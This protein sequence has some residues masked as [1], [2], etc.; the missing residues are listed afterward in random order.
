M[1]DSE[2]RT[3]ASETASAPSTSA[4]S[5]HTQAASDGT[6]SHS[7][8]APSDGLAGP[9]PTYLRVQ[10]S[11]AASLASRQIPACPDFSC[12]RVAMWV[13]S[14]VVQ[15]LLQGN[16]RLTS[17]LLLLQCSPGASS[18]ADHL[19]QTSSRENCAWACW[20]TLA[21]LPLHYA[22]VGYNGLRLCV[23]MCH[24][25]SCLLACLGRG[26]LRQCRQ[27][28]EPANQSATSAYRL[29]AARVGTLWLGFP[30][31][32]DR[33]PD[34]EWEDLLPPRRPGVPD[35]SEEEDD[36]VPTDIA[37]LVLTPAYSPER[38]TVNLL[39]PAQIEHFLSEVQAVRDVGSVA[40]FPRLVPAWPQPDA[41]WAV[42]L[43]APAW[44]SHCCVVCLDLWDIDGRVFSVTLPARASHAE[45]LAAAALPV[46]VAAA[47]YV[48]NAPFP[49]QAGDVLDVVDGITFT[50]LPEDRQQPVLFSLGGMLES[51]LPWAVGPAFPVAL[52][53]DWYCL[54]SQQGV[55]LFEL[56]PEGAFSYRRDIALASGIA[57]SSLSMT[58]GQPR[59]VNA[60]VHGFPCRT[61]IGVSGIVGA[62]VETAS[63]N[64]L[65]LLD[66]RELLLSWKLLPFASD[67]ASEH[68]ARCVIGFDV[69][70]G[71]ELAFQPAPH[72]EGRWPASDGLI[73]QVSLRR[74]GRVANGSAASA[75]Y[76]CAQGRV[77]GTSPSVVSQD[78]LSAHRTH[79]GKRWQLYAAG[80]AHAHLTEARG[81]ER[82]SPPL[83]L[84][85][86]GSFRASTYT[87]VRVSK[88]LGARKR[89]LD[90]A[91]A[92]AWLFVVPASAVQSPH[93]A[94][95]E[96]ARLPSRGSCRN[97]VCDDGPCTA[98]EFGGRPIPT[99]VRGQRP[100]PGV[101]SSVSPAMPDSAT[102]LTHPSDE[103]FLATLVTLLEESARAPQCPA[104]FLASTLIEALVEHYTVI[105]G[106]GSLRSARPTIALQRLLSD[107]APLWP[108]ESAQVLWDQ[109]S[110]RPAFEP[111]SVSDMPSLLGH[112]MQTEL[113]LGPV[114]FQISPQQLVSFLQPDVSLVPGAEV[115]LRLDQSALSSLCALPHPRATT[116]T[117]ALQCFTDG[118]FLPSTATQEAQCSWACV[119]ICPRS[120]ERGAVSGP[121]PTWALEQGG[122][123][124]AFLGECCA[125]LAASWI[126]ATLFHHRA[127]A[128][129]SDCQSAIGV[130]NGTYSAEPG[131]FAATLRGM[132]IFVRAFAPHPPA[133]TYTPGHAGSLGN[134]LA[135]RIAKA[136]ARR[137]VC[138]HLAWSQRGAAAWWQSGGDV[139]S[140]CSLLV[141]SLRGSVVYPRLGE[142]LPPC[143]DN[144][145]LDNRQLVQPFLPEAESASPTEDT[146]AWGTFS[147]C[148]CSFNVLSL[149]SLT[150]EGTAADGLAFQPARPTLLADRLLAAGAQIAMLQETRTEAGVHRT[151]GYL[152]Y[153][154]GALQGTLGVEIW[155]REHSLLFT[156]RQKGAA[157]LRLEQGSL[158]VMHKDPRRL[159][160]L[161]SQDGF[162]LLLV[163]LHAPHRAG[164]AADI[165][166][167]WTETDH[168]L[169]AHGS[170]IPVLAGGD[171]NASVGFVLAAGIGDH[172][173]EPQDEPG[174]CLADLLQA[175][176]LWLPCTFAEMHAGPSGTYVQKRSGAL[177]RIDYI[178]CPESWRA[179]N[180]STW[181]D[182]E[183]H[184]GQTY[185]D[186]IATLMSVRATVCLG[187][188][189]GRC[190]RHRFDS[191]AMLT[192]E[193]R[194][195][196]AS[197]LEKAPAIP[198]EA[199]PHAHAA[200]LVAYIQRSLTEE[201]PH[202]ALGE[203][204]VGG[205]LRKAE[206]G[207]G[208]Y[209]LAGT[210]PE[211]GSPPSPGGTPMV[212]ACCKIA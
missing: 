22:F 153:A 61:V 21:E 54:C 66:C 9:P 81:R 180:V 210:G 103:A 186:H 75:P 116:A 18:G 48:A 50:F 164:E 55:S 129:Q 167:W 191:R 39:I 77:A 171:L 212:A 68:A 158:L 10:G 36:A 169:H 175:H 182:P 49:V 132:G 80:S 203:R 52:L 133:C 27:Q 108:A 73:I 91:V 170:S 42:V 140:W 206:P 89:S 7:G 76:V 28:L 11:L 74:A 122:R 33:R 90:V 127:V 25:L 78:G 109:L 173:A 43:A 85:Q 95:E 207:A 151:Q 29:Q 177:T 37:V 124:S 208:I 159:M 6:P 12:S 200:T 23:S 64:G 209:G 139:L 142:D 15:A 152:R 69:P 194:R 84:A 114:G 60:A 144:L 20:R 188:A 192:P 197:I 82:R 126:S 141:T 211:Y 100:W 196:V 47:I 53:G 189:K 143:A 178:A 30:W 205:A 166:A 123:P 163:S 128:M 193:G 130:F 44:G 146:G 63:A 117:T 181:T 125:L 172:D 110:C 156:P 65:C 201:F 187:A 157:R 5:P 120:F 62:C 96:S 101:C 83:K 3:E 136:V 185:V 138:G 34:D 14:L 184:T 107:P 46:A 198:W 13:C 72:P 147:V 115:I 87:R 38:F 149:N 26:H 150:V 161:Y 8:D 71:F 137:Q 195:K 165:Q 70:E 131:S 160:L 179:G 93:V 88:F 86:F 112:C 118:S 4:S 16:C 106:D 176:Q 113:S 134:E 67:F 148:V 58:P 1:S 57:P 2:V 155:V 32:Y 40:T 168:L 154:S 31:R 111:W 121:V 199:T 119:F 97:A 59:P 202:N 105:K 162:R 19:Q 24:F 102:P 183:V 190:T 92:L 51:H 41:R 94:T 79:S 204:D 45:L 99:P 98:P 145:G 135:D 104:F 174:A 56:R 35:L 17:F